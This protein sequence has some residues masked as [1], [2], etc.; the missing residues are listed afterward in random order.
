MDVQQFY[1]ISSYIKCLTYF[2]CPTCKIFL[3]IPFIC[4]KDETTLLS[5]N[6]EVLPVF[7]ASLL[8]K[9]VGISKLVNEQVVPF[10]KPRN[11]QS[12]FNTALEKNRSPNNISPM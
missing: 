1:L 8:A 9:T 10:F 5:T 3:K 11:S 12:A 7:S 2:K 4:L 6:F